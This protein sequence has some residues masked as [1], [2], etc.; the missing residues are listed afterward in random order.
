MLVLVTTT[1]DYLVGN[2]EDFDFTIKYLIDTKWEVGNPNNPKPDLIS[3]T[4][5]GLN[6]VWPKV[7]SL[8]AIYFNLG[9]ETLV[10]HS[11]GY[12]TYKYQR[13][14]RVDI[15]GPTDVETGRIEREINR[16]LGENFPNSG[17]RLKKSN[18]TEDSAIASVD[19]PT[20]DFV[21]PQ[22][23]ESI[24]LERHSQLSGRFGVNWQKTVV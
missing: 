17:R 15:F 10:E 7:K 22:F 6:K 14:V 5:K 8:S 23:L 2:W 21:K 11:S 3:Q 20:I 16:I 19:K 1:I 18:G 12:G 24:E 4:E 9:N 13:I